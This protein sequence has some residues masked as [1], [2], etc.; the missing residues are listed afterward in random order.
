MDDSGR[1][2]ILKFASDAGINYPVL[3]GTEKAA[4][5]YGG[6]EGLPVTFYIGRDGRIAKRVLG[7]GNHRE[8]EEDVKLILGS[9]EPL[10]TARAGQ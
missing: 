8:V 9:R 1:D 2:T 6:V 7:L 3:Q 10:S 5:S 4:D